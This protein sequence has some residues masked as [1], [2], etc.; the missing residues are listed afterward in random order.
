MKLDFEQ[1]V[2]SNLSRKNRNIY[3]LPYLLEFPVGALN[4]SFT[5]DTHKH[6][7]ITIY[8]NG[9]V[10]YNKSRIVLASPA[11]IGQLLC[12]NKNKLGIMN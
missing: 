11:I 4:S 10:M 6:S 5:T 3:P 7:R 2:I 8:F 1:K 9:L 12:F